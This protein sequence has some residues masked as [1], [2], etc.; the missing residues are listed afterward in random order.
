MRI[1]DLQLWVVN[2]P[3]TSA[4]QSSFDR[5]RGTTRTLLKLDTDAG[6]S[7]WGETFRGT[8]TAKLIEQYRELIVGSDPAD[9]NRLTAKLRMTPFFYG[10]LGYAAIA[11]IEMAC[12]DIT[13]R[14]AGTSLAKMLGGRVRD[15]VPVSGLVTPGL[16]ADG[17]RAAD[18]PKALA[19]ASVAL[20]EERGFDVLKLKG[21]SD[22][23]RDVAA[24]SEVRRRLPDV[25]LRI[26]P[27]AAW[28]VD[29]S[30]WA[31]RRLVPLDLQYLEDP[32]A[33]LTGMARVRQSVDIPLCTNMCVVRL[34]DVAP[35]IQLNAVDVIHGDVHKWG[36]VGAVRRLAA[37]CNAFGL[38]M[39]LHSGGELGISTACHLQLAAATPEIAYAIDSMYYLLRDDVVEQPFDVKDGVLT[40][41]GGVGLGVDVDLEKVRFYA[42]QHEA[43]GDWVR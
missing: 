29:T 32:C 27:N 13:S 37:I 33:G 8:P 34:E 28:S 7:G 1:T 22:A 31:A 26:D 6:V 10:Y 14:S 3:F 40:V 36:G 20:R 38:G 39:N 35:G 23:R 43:E 18:L 5:R 12:L 24:V 30:I 9:L 16:V 19:D 15:V 25:G 42:A 17:T 2:V 11:G 21:S 4:F 41:P